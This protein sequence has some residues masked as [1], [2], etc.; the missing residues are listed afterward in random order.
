MLPLFQHRSPHQLE[1][2][3][4]SPRLNMASGLAIRLLIR[5]E[6]EI[7]KERN[8]PKKRTNK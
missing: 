4:T 2:K 3:C 7:K 1:M 8:K 6:N 5:L